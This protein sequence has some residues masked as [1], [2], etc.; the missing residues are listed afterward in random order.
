LEE[1][2]EDEVAEEKREVA[3]RLFAIKVLALMIV[4]SSC[5]E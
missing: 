2:G 5:Q 1:I 4:V 3:G